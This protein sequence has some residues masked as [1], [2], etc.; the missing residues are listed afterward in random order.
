MAYRW[1][2]GI[3]LLAGC[4][5][6]T[7]AGVESTD[8]SIT[9]PSEDAM[10]DALPA[11]D[12]DV[13]VPDAWQRPDASPGCVDGDG[14]GAL[15][16]IEPGAACEPADCDDDD[17]L[18]FP[19]QTGA[20]TVPKASGDF[21]YNCDGVEQKLADTT[22]GGGC[23]QEIFGPCE[24]TGWLGSVPECG[25]PG[26]WHKCE[27]GLFSCDETERIDAVMPCN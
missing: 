16:S 8:A 22:L 21:D 18:V 26:T 11:A 19:G 24:G 9:K 15:K 23:H 20:F 17:E 2:W 13:E 10:V 27:S 1:M 12:A 14:D 4:A 5:F 6:D 7:S 25:E 3:L